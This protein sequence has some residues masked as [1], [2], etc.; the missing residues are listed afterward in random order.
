MRP[1]FLTSRRGSTAG[2]AWLIA[3]V[4]IAAWLLFA[5]WAV[6]LAVGILAAEGVVASTLGFWSA[7][8]I[9]LLLRV[10]FLSFSATVKR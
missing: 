5:G 4:L 9:A 6:M 2:G 7:T 8:A 10:G 3:L 1:S